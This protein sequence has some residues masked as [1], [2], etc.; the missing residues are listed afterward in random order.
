MIAELENIH[1]NNDG[2]FRISLI[3]DHGGYWHYHPEFELVLNL[4]SCGTRIIGD[5]VELFDRYDMTFI[6]G[7]IPHSWNHYRQTDGVPRD[8]SIVCNFGAGSLGETFL[9]QHEMKALRDLFSEAERG[10]AF[11]EA[12]A[13]RAEPMLMEMLTQT[14]L[15]KMISFFSLMRV[16]CSA[17]KKRQLCSPDYKRSNDTRGNKRMSDVY[18]FIRE[19]YAHPVTLGKVASIANMSPFAFSRYFKKNSGAG[20]VEYINQVRTNRACYL[21]RETE[22]SIHEIAVECGFQSISNFNKQFRRMTTMAPREYRD[23]YRD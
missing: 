5:N 1:F 23:G 6:S 12:D 20:V 19:N 22:N 8:H 14:G 7:N 17:E 13:R 21:L 15:D 10:L 2:G 9:G 4:K 16:L 18:T 11:S 3:S